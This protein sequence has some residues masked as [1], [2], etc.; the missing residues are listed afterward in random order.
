MS[1]TNKYLYFSE[2]DLE[3]LEESYENR[4]F[5]HQKFFLEKAPISKIYEAR[6]KK[7]EQFHAEYKTLG[8]M[9]SD[10]PLVLSNFEFTGDNVKQ[11]FHQHH[12]VRN[13]LKLM[14][15]QA[16]SAIHLIWI[17]RKMVDIEKGYAAL[18]AIDNP[19]E[20]LVSKEE[21]PMDLLAAIIEWN[22]SGF[23]TFTELKTHLDKAPKVLQNELYRL[24]L[25]TN[26]Y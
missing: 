11:L 21:D 23:E 2:Q 26:K 8:G 3:D 15:M 13:Q 5:E 20:V 6:I 14:L 17:A 1:T 18:W 4:M 7:I 9:H 12:Q 10:E 25:L 22:D 16:P 19:E 24:S